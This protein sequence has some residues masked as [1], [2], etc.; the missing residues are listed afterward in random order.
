MTDVTREDFKE[1]KGAVIELTHA[2]TKQI[3]RDERR[4]ADI[5]RLN[6]EA[7]VLEKRVHELETKVI[8]TMMTA[9]SSN[10]QI[11]VLVTVIISSISA[12]AIGMLFRMAGTT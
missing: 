7:D 12:G 3:A 5:V 6:K 9:I 8:P 2:V 11:V 1:L 4:E 10:K